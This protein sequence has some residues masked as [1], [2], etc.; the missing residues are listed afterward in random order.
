[1]ARILFLS[2]YPLDTLDSAPKVRSFFLHKELNKL[3]KTY[4]IEGTRWSRTVKLFIWVL[5]GGLFRNKAIY[6]ESNTTIG[7]PIEIVFLILAK[8]IGKK[9]YVFIRDAYPIFPEE[10]P[11]KNLKTKFLYL[12]WK[13]SIAV[14]KFS[15]TKLLFP[16]QSLANL[17]NLPADKVVLLPPA[18][19]VN[20]PVFRPI[21]SHIVGY[22]GEVSKQAGYEIMLKSIELVRNKIPDV[23]LVIV[24]RKKET[25]PDKKTY[26]QW[27]QASYSQL[28]S[29]L[30]DCS[31][32]LIP[33]TSKGYNLITLPIKLFD[34]MSLGKVVV[35]TN[36]PEAARVIDKEKVGII[37]QDTPESLAASI[38]YLLEHPE[39]TKE[40]QKNSSRAI[41]ERHSWVHRAQELYKLMKSYE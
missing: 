18:A 10:F 17:F 3:E 32:C 37:C 26:L 13:I 21:I 23:K 39:K 29:V 20:R 28:E 35:S 33:R 27:K 15:A 12:G 6:V 19:T 1:M 40:F 41:R 38:I 31:I 24:A 34:Y 25:R 4:L 22:I 36:L 7:S 16:T 30:S 5:K 11:A 2:M 14:Y 8:V 9:N